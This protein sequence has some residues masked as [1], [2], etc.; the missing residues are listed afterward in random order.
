MDPKLFFIAVDGS[1][2]RLSPVEV[3]GL[4]HYL[5]GFST[6][7]GGGGFLP[8]TVAAKFLRMNWSSLAVRFDS[9]FVESGKAIDEV[10]LA[11]HSVECS[12]QTQTYRASSEYE[13]LATILHSIDSNWTNEQAFSKSLLFLKEASSRQAFKISKNLASLT[14][15]WSKSK[16]SL[17]LLPLAMDWSDWRHWIN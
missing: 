13:T 3:G 2:I 12:R 17:M 4:S 14:I 1:E 8:S 5:Q 9:T 10:P 11:R 6:I 7:P 16:A 15:D